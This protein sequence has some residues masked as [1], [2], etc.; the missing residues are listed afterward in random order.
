MVRTR[1]ILVPW[2]HLIRSQII[3]SWEPIQLDYSYHIY[4]SVNKFE[5]DAW[6]W[7]ILHPL[8]V[9]CHTLWTALCNGERHGT[10]KKA[11]RINCLAQ[12]KRDLLTI[13]KYEPEQVLAS[14]KDLFETPID[15]LLTFLPMKSAN[16]SYLTAPSFSKAV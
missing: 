8:L 1:L 2:G 13:Y 12:L 11:Q 14:D 6:H 3:S 16:G 7:K 4:P 9:N 5:P 15:E 10:G